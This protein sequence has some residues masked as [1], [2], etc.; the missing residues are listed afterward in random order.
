MPGWLGPILKGLRERGR[1]VATKK[2]TGKLA[3]PITV[4]K[5]VK[6]LRRDGEESMERWI[7]GELDDRIKLLLQHYGISTDDDKTIYAGL[8]HLIVAL[9]ADHVPGFQVRAIGR[10]PKVLSRPRRGARGR[11]PTRRELTFSL[12][13]LI[14]RLKEE[15]G[16]RGRGSD[17]KALEIWIGE[18]AREHNI[19]Q[20]NIRG[21]VGHF[22]K[23]LSEGRTV[24]S[25]K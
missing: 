9:T 23:V 1:E 14:D 13:L 25:K 22:Q 11:P 21:T 5:I 15:R 4:N 19:S 7:A 24:N 16:L 12:P 3:E 2:Y 10:P 20:A 8:I 6:V 17:K 18:L